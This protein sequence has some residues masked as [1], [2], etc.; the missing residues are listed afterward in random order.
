MAGGAGP[1]VHGARV[2]GA[3]G[4]ADHVGSGGRPGHGHDHQSAGG[5]GGDADGGGA[6]SICHGGAECV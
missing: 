3:G 2:E 4:G 1:P 6:I 5:E